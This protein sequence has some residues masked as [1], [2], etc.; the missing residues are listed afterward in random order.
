MPESAI[1]QSTSDEKRVPHRLSLLTAS[2]Q[3]EAPE[4]RVE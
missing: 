3:N 1:S 2:G 4:D